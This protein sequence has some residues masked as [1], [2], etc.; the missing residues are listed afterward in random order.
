VGDVALLAGRLVGAHGS[1]TGI[2][3][4][5]EA[6]EIAVARANE[7]GLGHVRFL[8]ADAGEFEAETKYD[9]VIGR[10]I[11][12]HSREPVAL[13]RRAQGFVR[14]GGIVAFQDFDLS[15]VGS[16]FTD[17]PTWE[18]CG[19]AVTALFERAGLEPRAGSFLYTWFLEAGLPV[20]K[21][22]LE[23]LVDGGE[24]SL[25]YEWLAETVRSLLPKMLALKV[26]EP[27][28]I[29]ID[30]LEETLRREALSAKR[31]CVGPAM[32]GAFVR[33]LQPVTL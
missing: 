5:P 30:R 2:D 17:L 10:L 27:Y 16:R 22:R 13:L 31:P 29:D 23:F 21:C 15:V 3:V 33:K 8:Q 26:L 7:D 28:T 4:D 25:Y 14:P 1:V 6:L 12:I 9:A 24:G 19:K 20:P 32:G 11:L 18:A